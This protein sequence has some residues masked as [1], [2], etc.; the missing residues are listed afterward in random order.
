MKELSENNGSK[1][2]QHY[3]KEFVLEIL[4]EVANIGITGASRKHQI[5]DSTI[6]SWL[7]EYAEEYEEIKIKTKDTFITKANEVI[8]KYL[9]HLLDENVIKATS[10]R[11]SA[12]IIGTL[13]DK[14][15]LETGEPTERIETN[16]ID[17]ILWRKIPQNGE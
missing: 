1:K 2:R 10:G 13:R 8:Q 6:S 4:T 17:N 7:K 14:I 16:D 15:S 12:I 3:S 11:D 9:A 5:P